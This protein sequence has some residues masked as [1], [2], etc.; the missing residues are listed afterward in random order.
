[1]KVILS[2][3]SI[4]NPIL[5]FWN[6]YLAMKSIEILNHFYNLYQLSNV[7]FELF[8]LLSSPEHSLY[9]Y[10]DWYKF[11]HNF[12]GVQLLDLILHNFN[13][14]VQFASSVILRLSKFVNNSQF[15]N[16]FLHQY[17]PPNFLYNTASFYKLKSPFYLHFLENEFQI[18]M[19]INIDVQF[20][21]FHVVYLFDALI[22]F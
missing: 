21:S 14:V 10:N 16:L 22:E 6:C 13:F 8:S 4:Q 17:N 2:S 20:L 12:D 5:Y 11:W 1:M 18:V 7:L 15:L 19:L 3:H 9:L